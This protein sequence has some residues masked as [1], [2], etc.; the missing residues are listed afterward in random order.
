MFEL[1]KSCH[2]LENFLHISTCYV[3][4]DKVG[5]IEEEI[6]DLEEDAEQ[7]IE[8]LL[9]LSPEEL[10]NS[11]K[12]ILGALP[13]TYVF[14]KGAVER[15]IQKHRPKDITITLVRPSIIGAALRDPYPG[16][17]ENVTACTAIFLLG[18]IGMIRYIPGD[19]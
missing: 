5:Y 14:T 18:G 4:S 7:M 17:V 3:N 16:W 19:E 12:E 1:A 9:N 10:E 11:T 15:I 13:N 6:Y 2:K 8:G